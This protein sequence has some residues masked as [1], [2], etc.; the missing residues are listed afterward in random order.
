MS[1]S[2]TFQEKALEAIVSVS[3]KISKLVCEYGNQPDLLHLENAENKAN[4]I[5]GEF[6]E[7]L[8]FLDKEEIKSELLGKYT[9]YE[10][11]L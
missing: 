5:V 3:D 10:K 6:E 2:R 4:P 11:L 1:I 9:S 7:E 8:E